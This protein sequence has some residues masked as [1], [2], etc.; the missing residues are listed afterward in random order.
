MLAWQQPIF[1]PI[2]IKISFFLGFEPVTSEPVAVVVDVNKA[3][4]VLCTLQADKIP[5][6]TLNLNFTE[7]EE[8]SFSIE[9]DGE[10]HLTGKITFISEVK[11][12]HCALQICI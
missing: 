8:V 10:V 5:Q 11:H 3:Q 2:V 12:A 1:F 9:G 4:F 7:G 6:Q